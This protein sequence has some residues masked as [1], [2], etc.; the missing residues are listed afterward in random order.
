MTST[1]LQ[2][3][4]P[5][6][7]VSDGKAA[8]ERWDNRSR[9]RRTVLIGLAIG[10]V[11]LA[12]LLWLLALGHDFGPAGSLQVF[13]SG[14]LGPGENS[15]H[16]TDWYSL[17]HV[18]FGMTL[19]V[20]IDKIK[21]RWPASFKLFAAIC[22]SAVWEGIENTPLVIA[23]FT[24]AGTPGAYAGDSI[25]N[26]LGDMLSVALGFACAASLPFGATI[27]F[28]LLLELAVTLTIHDGLVLGT[29]RL[30]GFPY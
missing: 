15:R 7:L 1:P 25:V 22:G 9:S 2:D 18:V 13:W 27:G 24:D 16:F 10:A 5:R 30:F 26:S 29:M 23:L 6:R 21:P 19:F 28:A 4:L 3:H 17:L 14:A 20:A 12:L 8:R 11:N